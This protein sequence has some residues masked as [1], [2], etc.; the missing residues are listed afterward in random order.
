MR[1]RWRCALLAVLLSASLPGFA[2]E[3]DELRKLRDSTIALVNALVDQGIL[4][5]AKADAIIAQAQ[6]AGANA[7]GAGSAPNA[8]STAAAGAPPP[9]AATPP[10]APAAPST[11]GTS[12]EPPLAPGTVRVPYV[13]ESVKQD[14]TN[15]VKQDVLAQAKTER[16]G[17]PG[18]F[19]EWL[20]RFNWYGDMRVRYEADTFPPGNAPVAVLQAYGVNIANSTETDERLRFRA[21][22]GFDVSVGDTVTVGMRLASGGV[23]AGGNPGSE[24][25]TLGSYEARSTVGFDRAFIGYHPLSWLEASAGIVG[26]PFFRPTSLVWADDVSL[27]GAVLNLHPQFNDFKFFAIAGAFPI[28]QNDPSPLS[29]AASKWLYAYQGGGE[30]QFNKESAVRVGAALYDYRNIEGIPNPT[31]YS[32]AYDN[33]AAT[34]RQ[35]GNTVFDINGLLNTQQG[36]QNYLWGLASKFHVL[37]LSG[38]VNLGFIGPV[39]LFV[40]ADWVKNLGFNEQEIEQRIHYQV[41]RQVDGWQTRFTI[42]HQTMQQKYAWQAYVGYRF[43]Q[44]DATLDAFTD[45]DFHLGGTDAEGYYLGGRFAFE[46][47][48]F[49]NVR[50]FSAKQIDGVELAGADAQLTGLPLAINVL[51]VDVMASF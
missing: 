16:W 20:R 48:T 25:Q 34:F 45:Q 8:P 5:R 43:V 50:W 24:N 19:P 29:S 4:T 51:Q 10:G 18:A 49:I 44:R 6:Q 14:I 2:D 46:R 22:F 39:H 17:E 41:N 33:T 1:T 37:N 32:T 15:E 42:G 40:D 27:G 38:S 30:W 13:P 21:R 26:M 36:T 7:P 28:L 35:T 9:G 47:N 12:T 23:G 11:A 31:I 3:A